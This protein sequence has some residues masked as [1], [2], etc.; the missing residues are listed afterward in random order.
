MKARHNYLFNSFV[1]KN[2]EITAEV[3]EKVL[4]AWKNYFALKFPDGP[5]CIERFEEWSDSIRDSE[6]LKLDGKLALNFKTLNQS[7][8]ALMLRKTLAPN[9]FLERVRDVLVLK[10]DE[11]VVGII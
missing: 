8:E 6:A 7:Y 4:T 2:K 9:V 1:E 10:L 11:E 5:K 3:Y